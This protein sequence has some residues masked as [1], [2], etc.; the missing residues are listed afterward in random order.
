MN[1]QRAEAEAPIRIEAVL[2]Q[3]N[4]GAVGGPAVPPEIT[5]V[6]RFVGQRIP[7]RWRLGSRI[8]LSHWLNPQQTTCSTTLVGTGVIKAI[9][10][11]QGDVEFDVT[12][13]YGWLA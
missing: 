1:T 2:T 9:D 8:R 10:W 11:L 12:G 7:R 13:P 6:L 3:Y 5:G 4:M